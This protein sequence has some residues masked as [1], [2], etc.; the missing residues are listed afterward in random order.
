MNVIWAIKQLRDN[1]KS[2][3]PITCPGVTTYI[4][5]LLKIFAMLDDSN[6]KVLMSEEWEGK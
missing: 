4:V 1:K 3:C 2:E 6:Y 5:A